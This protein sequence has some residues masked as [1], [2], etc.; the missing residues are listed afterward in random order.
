MAV[1]LAVCDTLC[2]GNDL[3]NVSSILSA[4]MMSGLESCFTQDRGNKCY[5]DLN[6]DAVQSSRSRTCPQTSGACVCAGWL[7]G[8]HSFLY[9]PLS[10]GFLVIRPDSVSAKNTLCKTLSLVSQD[11]QTDIMHTFWNAVT[12]ILSTEFQKASSGESYRSE[13][14]PL[15]F[16]W[17]SA[18]TKTR[19]HF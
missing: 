4:Y 10:V 5:E 9:Q 8:V 15:V 6:S 1:V 13:C 12:Q 11:G 19:P 3:R 7:V 16:A 18:H 14:R 2:P 17:G